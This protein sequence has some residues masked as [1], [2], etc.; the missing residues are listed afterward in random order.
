[1][2]NTNRKLNTILLSDEYAYIILKHSRVATIDYKDLALVEKTP[3]FVDPQNYV[4]SSNDRKVLL[5]RVIMAASLS[6]GMD[7]DHIDRNPLNN[8]RD[9]LRVCT[10]SENLRRAVRKRGHL[11]LKGVVERIGKTG[12]VYRAQICVGTIDGKRNNKWLGTFKTIE[13]AARAYDAAAKLYFG[14]FVDLN[15]PNE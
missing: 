3:W 15:F 10:R 2:G 13:E 1:M 6:S 5:H 9:N 8:C 14:D 12:V 4:H 7:V 11:K